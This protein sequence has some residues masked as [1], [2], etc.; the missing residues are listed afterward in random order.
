VARTG[1][2]C[3]ADIG[4]DAAIPAI[5]D[6]VAAAGVGP[7]RMIVQAPGLPPTGPLATIEPDA[8]GGPWR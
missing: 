8:L 5:A 2:E 4:S 1:A 6:A 3:A 7:V